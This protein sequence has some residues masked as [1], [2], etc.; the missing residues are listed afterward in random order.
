M[1]RTPSKNALGASSGSRPTST[2]KSAAKAA[3]KDKQAAGKSSGVGEEKGGEGDLDDRGVGED[4]DGILPSTPREDKGNIT[5]PPRR[6]KLSSAP[7]SS[8]KTPVKK[9]GAAANGRQSLVSADIL[10]VSAED[11]KATKRR[12]TVPDQAKPSNRG[13][14]GRMDSTIA[15]VPLRSKT[16]A[17]KASRPPL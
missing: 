14:R 15:E 17:A 3:P 7:S 1:L 8:S 16:S 6:S 10:E 13:P 12:P 5:A 9:R 4:K 2:S 11:K